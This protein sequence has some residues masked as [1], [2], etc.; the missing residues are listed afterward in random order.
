VELLRKGVS[1]EVDSGDIERIRKPYL[2]VPIAIE[3]EKQG[4]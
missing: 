4:A 2:L 3:V 1:V